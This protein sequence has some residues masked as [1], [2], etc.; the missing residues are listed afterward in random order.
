MPHHMGS[1]PACMGL[2]FI[3]AAEKKS[4]YSDVKLMHDDKASQILSSVF[5]VGPFP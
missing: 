1:H 2:A 5:G 3:V 4:R